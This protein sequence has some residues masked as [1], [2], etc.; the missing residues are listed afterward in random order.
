MEVE[1]SDILI[2]HDSSLAT[3]KQ[4]SVKRKFLCINMFDHE[5]PSMIYTMSYLKVGVFEHMYIISKFNVYQQI[6]CNNIILIGPALNT[7]CTSFLARK[8]MD[9][10]FYRVQ[11]TFESVKDTRIE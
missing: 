7:Y 1:E 9:K 10:D 2:I 11:C 3:I 4:K 8:D 5:G 6:K